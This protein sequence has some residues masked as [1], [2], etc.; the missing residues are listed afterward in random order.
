M[1]EGVEVSGVG[2]SSGED[3]VPEEPPLNLVLYMH[4]RI[5]AYSSNIL[6]ADFDPMDSMLASGT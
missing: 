4:F 3:L 6:I 5:F 1:R 2:W